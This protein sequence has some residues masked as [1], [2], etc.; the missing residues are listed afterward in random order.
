MEICDNRHDVS[1]N[2]RTLSD[3]LI[4][5][6]SQSRPIQCSH[7]PKY[8]VCIFTRFANIQRFKVGLKTGLGILMT[9][10]GIYLIF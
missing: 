7:K 5:D 6:V 2:H 4:K 3:L 8:L 1:H 10:A 9:V